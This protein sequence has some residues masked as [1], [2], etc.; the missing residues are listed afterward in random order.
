MSMF[1]VGV[2]RANG[3]RENDQAGAV[4][5]DPTGSVASSVAA[6]NVCWRHPF[7]S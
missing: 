7:P 2:I 4:F 3:F 6:V 1:S 5:S